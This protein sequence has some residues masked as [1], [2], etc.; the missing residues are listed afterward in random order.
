MMGDYYVSPSLMGDYYV[1]FTDGGLLCL[2]INNGDYYVSP[3][4]M[5]N[6]Y[7]SFNDGGLLCL[8]FT[9]GGLLCL[10]FSDK[11]L[12]RKRKQENGRIYCK[13]TSPYQ[14]RRDIIVPHHWDSNP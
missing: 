6:Y 9:D 5:G 1:S 8:P 7:I 11:K 3:S 14:W 10:S 12:L 4:L 13:I 2:S